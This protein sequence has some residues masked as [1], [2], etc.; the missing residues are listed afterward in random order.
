METT[1]AFARRLADCTRTVY[2]RSRAVG[3]RTEYKPMCSL[4][5]DDRAAVALAAKLDFIA[6]VAAEKRRLED[7]NDDIPDTDWF[8]AQAFR[9][10]ATKYQ[11]KP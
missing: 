6:E 8:Y 11:E 2:Q 3:L 9:N 5:E 10:V 1:E 7:L 4:I